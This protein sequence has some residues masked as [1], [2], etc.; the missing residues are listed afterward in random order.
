MVRWPKILGYHAVAEVKDDPNNICVS[1]E[2]F[3]AQMLYLKRRNLRGVSMR[4]L[5]SAMNTGNAE[6][7]VGITFDDGYE[8]LLQTALPVLER[9]GFSC[10]IFVPSSLLGR[11]NSWDT[12][13]QM[14]L[15]QVGHVREISKQGVEIGSHG[16]NHIALSGLNPE[17]LEWEASG[18]RQVLSEIL[19]EEV[20]GFCYPYASVD[21]RVIKAVQRADYT[22]ACAA[23][24]GVWW[25]GAYAIP[26]IFV[27]EKDNAIRL[28]VKFWVYSKYVELSRMQFAKMAY[29]SIHHTPVWRYAARFWYR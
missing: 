3:E 6:G 4:A 11:E 1:P 5:L 14:K 17:S 9:L 20:E 27:G 8:H 10:T 15:L 21:G 12:V 29:S 26:R 19:G 2:R 24:G 28:A 18:S 25:E 13:P 16:A 23:L 7:L 22:Y